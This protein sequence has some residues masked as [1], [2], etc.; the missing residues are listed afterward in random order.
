MWHSV[1]ASSHIVVADEPPVSNCHIRLGITSSCCQIIAVHAI[2]T[3]MCTC[4]PC[5]CWYHCIWSDKWCAVC[6][7]QKASYVL[8]SIVMIHISCVDCVDWYN[9]SHFQVCCDASLSNQDWRSRVRLLGEVNVSCTWLGCWIVTA[10]KH[11]CRL[12]CSLLLLHTKFISGSYCLLRC[13]VLHVSALALESS[14]LYTNRWLMTWWKW[15]LKLNKISVV[16][17]FHVRIQQ[18]W[19]F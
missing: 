7:K 6:Q 12:S 15:S 17:V 5:W 13:V 11:W 16:W 1:A 14:Y 10:D 18:Q 19:H 2:E 9:N 3:L 4:S 8:L